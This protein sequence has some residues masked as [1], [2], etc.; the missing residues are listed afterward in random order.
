MFLFSFLC[1]FLSRSAYDS[2]WVVHV[3]VLIIHLSCIFFLCIS[4]FELPSISVRYTS[5][6]IN[7]DSGELLALRTCFFLFNVLIYILYFAYSMSCKFEFFCTFSCYI[8]DMT[9]G[10]VLMLIYHSLLLV[11][12]FVH[13]VS[14]YK[15]RKWIISYILCI[16]PLILNIVIYL[17]SSTSYFGLTLAYSGV[18]VG[19]IMAQF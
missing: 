2:Y 6:I 12:L 14:R 17:L 18:I 1:S 3:F 7:L 5:A 10:L 16:L 9:F 11:G 4:Q 15:Y 8:N 13:L 19:V